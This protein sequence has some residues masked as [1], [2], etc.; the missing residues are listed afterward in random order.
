M[1]LISGAT[2][3]LMKYYDHLVNF[4][5]AVFIGVFGAVLLVMFFVGVMS[6][7]AIEKLLPFII[8]FNAVL[9]GYNLVSRTKNRFKHKRI[10]GLISGIVIVVIA[11]LVL[12]IAF[13]YYTGGYI[14]YM[15]NFLFLVFIGGVFS[16]LGTI[17]A[18]RYFKLDIMNN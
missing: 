6:I 8:G 2:R 1:V 16:W 15:T 10:W 7:G 12:N 4:V 5:H 17:L 11:V 9:T 13:Y 14:V 18:I 3:F